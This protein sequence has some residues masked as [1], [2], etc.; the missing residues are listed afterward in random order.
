MQ[1]TVPTDSSGRRLWA[2]MSDEQVVGFAKKLIKERGITGVNEL[3]QIDSGLHRI[4][5]IRELFCA[6]GFEN[7]P[8]KRRSWKSMN[9][10]EIVEYAKKVMTE[11]KIT[12]I[13]ELGRTDP[14]LH[15]ILTKRGLLDQVG[16]EEKYRNWKDM[17]DEGLIGLT[18]RTMKSKDITGRSELQ[19][20]D[21]GLYRVLVKRNLLDKVGFEDK[22]RSWKDVG[23]EEILE[24]AR[25]VMKSHKITSRSQLQEVD[26]GLCKILRAR[27]LM[28]E[29]RFVEKLRRWSDMSDGDL[30][31]FAKRV[32][33]DNGITGKREL[34][35]INSGAYNNLRKR[36][37]LDQVGFEEKRRKRRFWNDVS[38]EEIVGLARKLIEE[39]GIRS[40]LK[41]KAADSGLHAVLRVRN[42][43]DKLQFKE[44]SRTHTSWK[45]MTNEEIVEFARR[46]IKEK[47]IVTRKEL[48]TE[49]RGLS[50]VLRRRGLLDQ[51]FARIDQQKVDMAR[52]A[53]ID[54]LEAFAAN[55]NS[56][57][58]DE[59]A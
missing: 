37:L 15:T 33:K 31:E 22:R 12:G 36:G 6:V 19:E 3:G 32:M 25:E 44:K 50:A 51:V 57:S 17:D 21:P 26:S 10:E 35:N 59:V 43:L 24:L 27:G 13:G 42:L 38:D 56:I 40:R 8:R 29:V 48:R 55:D 7:R 39:N 45:D 34:E 41:F 9:D 11:K 16:F 1:F 54:A 4:L 20:S 52:D 47:T 58:E 53:V 2:K 23:D 46:L 5:R 49:H 30:I 14:G 18:R 28:D